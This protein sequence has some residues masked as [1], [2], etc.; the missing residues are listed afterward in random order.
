MP[1]KPTPW[2]PE[3]LLRMEKAVRFVQNK[4][5]DYQFEL[6]NSHNAWD[7]DID[8][9]DEAGGVEENWDEL[10]HFDEGDFNDD[11]D[12]RN[13]ATALA[14]SLLDENRTRTGSVGIGVDSSK[15]LDIEQGGVGG[16]GSVGKSSPDLSLEKSASKQKQRKAANHVRSEMELDM[17]ART[18]SAIDVETAKKG[19][20][21]LD[22][23]WQPPNWEKAR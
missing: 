2:T 1:E 12:E 9:D 8:D 23:P 3:E 18:F 16:A 22:I 5:I 20:Q 21:V 17:L 19:L 7:L 6:R 13:L 10:E 14:N 4:W 15:V 11:D